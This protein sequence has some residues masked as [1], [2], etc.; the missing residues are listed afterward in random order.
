MVYGVFNIYF[1][2]GSWGFLGVD[3]NVLEKILIFL[4]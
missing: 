2:V 1:F 3:V 4:V